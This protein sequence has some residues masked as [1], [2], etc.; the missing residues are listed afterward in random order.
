MPPKKPTRL[1]KITASDPSEKQDPQSE[2]SGDS[3]TSA[4]SPLSE[5]TESAQSEVSGPLSDKRSFA[6]SDS[7]QKLSKIYYSPVGFWKGATAIK[8]LSEASGLDQKIVKNWLIK[9]AIWQI[10]LPPPKRIPRPKFGIEIPN[11]VHQADLLF[12]PHD[13]VDGITYKYALTI[14]DIASRYKEAYPLET[15]SSEEVANAFE[16]IYFR[17][18]LNFPD[19]LQ[20]DPGREFMGEVKKL[21]K[22]KDSSIRYGRVNI[23]RDQAIV[24][25]W[26]KTLAEKLFG[27]QYAVELTLPKGFRETAWVKRLPEV[28]KSSNNEIT[29]LI[30]KKPAEAILE[31]T[32]VSETASFPGRFVGFNETTIPIDSLLRYLYE[33]GELEGGRKRATDPI[34]SLKIFEIDYIVTKPNQPRMYWLKNG[35]DRSFVREELLI[36]PK[37]TQNPPSNL[38][39]SE[40]R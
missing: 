7:D 6:P 37:N 16:E 20:V 15:K 32:V 24:E 30:N 35:P 40:P 29:R 34:W 17:S 5:Q 23:H 38:A 31:K 8:K 22:S 27:F 36:V 2:A 18:P 9:Q 12:L 25:R 33:P 19:L 1:K 26:N 10:Y 3:V 13:K 4:Q 11:E 28:V 14:V 39:A 21:F